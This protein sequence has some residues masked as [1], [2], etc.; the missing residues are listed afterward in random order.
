MIFDWDLPELHLYPVNDNHIGSSSADTDRQKALA[1]EISADELA[2]ILGLGDHLETIAMD[3]RRFLPWDLETPITPEALG[4][5]FR[6]QV[7]RFA[8]IWKPT[9]GQWLGL[10][11]GNHEIGALQRHYTNLAKALAEELKCPCLAPP[12]ETSAWVTIHY[13]PT[14]E[15]FPIFLLHGFGGGELRGSDALKLQRLLLRKQARLL[16][17]AHFHRP[18]VMAETVETADG[19]KLA[20][21]LIS[22]AI[23]HRHAYL[24]N[25]GGNSPPSLRAK[26]IISFHQDPEK[27]PASVKVELSEW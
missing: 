26:V 4:E 17:V 9:I 23:L 16:L 7:L 2:A 21:G 14:G 22:P 19:D 8:D 5:V 20:W 24:G 13:V 6:H 1:K 3:D 11:P 27:R 18:M 25:K 15:L 12:G 10:I